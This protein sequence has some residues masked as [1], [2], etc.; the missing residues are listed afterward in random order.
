MENVRSLTPVVATSGIPLLYGKPVQ[1][2]LMKVG[3]SAEIPLDGEVFEIDQII[4]VTFEARVVGVHF[5][6]NPRTGDLERKH[7][8]RVID[9][10][11]I[12]PL[13]GP[14]GV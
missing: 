4:S 14:D 6:V 10:D 8:L 7:R 9:V 5:D 11:R 2:S 3:S 12:T 13:T 1:A